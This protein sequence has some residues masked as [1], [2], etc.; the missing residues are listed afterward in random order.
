MR[1]GNADASSS[2]D[3]GRPITANDLCYRTADPALYNKGIYPARC[4]RAIRGKFVTVQK[5]PEAGN[6]PLHMVE[7]DFKYIDY[8]DSGENHRLVI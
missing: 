3:I 5:L 6:G 8:A 1:I 4:S 2:T 7:V